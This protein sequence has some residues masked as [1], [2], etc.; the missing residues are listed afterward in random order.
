MLFA[1]KREW[2]LFCVAFGVATCCVGAYERP[3]F[4]TYQPILDRMPFGAIPDP[5]LTNL[6]PVVNVAEQREKELLARQIHMSA[7]NIMPDG[8]TAIGF[9]DI[10]AKPPVNHYLHVGE[11]ADGWTVLDA[12]YDEE[13]A[14]I[15]KGGIEVSLQ[16][17]K[18]LIEPAVPPGG[19]ANPGFAAANQAV[20]A[21]AQINAGVIRPGES[22]VPG[23]RRETRNANAPTP[24][25]GVAAG[26]PPQAAVTPAAP[27]ASPSYTEL[28][29]QRLQAQQ[30]EKEAQ[31][32]RQEETLK[33]LAAAVA[34]EEIR[35]REQEAADAANEM[36]NEMDME[37]EE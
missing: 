22:G 34:N 13:T 11:S 7:V 28:R 12:D 37:H 1:M 26:R 18:G 10:S 8:R 31:D 25:P 35:K 23:L 6:V 4:D 32:R 36:I 16:L 20:A 9:T 5:S 27:A 2:I 21:A 19:R 29:E 30:A 33:R 3:R 24:A 15:K 17:G 14:T